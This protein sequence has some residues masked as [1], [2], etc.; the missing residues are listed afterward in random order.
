MDVIFTL[1]CVGLISE[2]S[3]FAR[4]GGKPLSLSAPT[5]VIIGL[6]GLA[7][8]AAMLL[9]LRAPLVASSGSRVCSQL[10]VGHCQTGLLS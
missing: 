10:S 1:I 9:M 4:R 2:S 6:V 7:A 8:V 5:K 3:Y